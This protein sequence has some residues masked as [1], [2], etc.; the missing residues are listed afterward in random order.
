[1]QPFP[2]VEHLDVLEGHRRQPLQERRHIGERRAVSERALLA[3][4]QG[5][6]MLPIVARLPVIEGAGHR[7]PPALARHGH[8]HEMG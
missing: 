7:R 4:D 6:V 1:M 5:H 8:G 2:L 3:L